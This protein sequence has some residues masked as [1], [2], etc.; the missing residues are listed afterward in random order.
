VAV[1][2]LRERG[3]APASQRWSGGGGNG[4]RWV[5]RRRLAGD[6]ATVEVYS[7]VVEASKGTRVTGLGK[8]EMRE[9][10]AEVRNRGKDR[11]IFNKALCFFFNNLNRVPGTGSGS[12]STFLG[13]R[14][15]TG[16]HR[17]RNF[18]TGPGTG[19]TESGSRPAGS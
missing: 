14:S 5:R 7:K 2:E 16:C 15:G 13:P 18:R 12:G 6:P 1:E 8:A 4:W 3:W 11:A 10:E 9:T 17:F 19:R